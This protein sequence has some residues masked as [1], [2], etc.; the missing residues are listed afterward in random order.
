M[1]SVAVVRSL[2][3]RHRASSW[4]EGRHT[5]HPRSGWS[6]ALKRQE[7][8]ES[9]GRTWWLIPITDDTNSSEE[10]DPEDERPIVG[11]SARGQTERQRDRGLRWR[12]DRAQVTTGRFVNVRRAAGAERRYGFAV[13][14]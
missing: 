14:K 1:V 6:K 5:P 11:S 12:E 3:R 13:R 8:Q 9:I 2:R 10:T 4:E 7:P